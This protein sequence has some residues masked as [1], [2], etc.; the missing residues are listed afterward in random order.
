V[1]RR[2]YNFELEMELNSPCVIDIVN[3]NRLRYDGYMMRRPNDLSK[4]S[5]FKATPQGMRRKG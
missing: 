2:R 3:M 4:E 1:Y 5:I